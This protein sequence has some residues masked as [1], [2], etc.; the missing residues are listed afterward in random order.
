MTEPAFTDKQHPPDDDDLARVLGESF[1]AWNEL[2]DLAKK[3]VGNTTEE[4]KFYGKKYGWQMKT[5][6]KKRNLFFLIP[7]EGSFTVV[8]IFG[9]RAVEKIME[10]SLAEDLKETLTSAKK[11]LE[12]RGLSVEVRDAARLDDVRV[13]LDTKLEK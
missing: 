8:F 1:Y 13:L 6:L 11:Y 10:S 9:D 12:G 2:R 5:I 7:G 3:Q 4:W